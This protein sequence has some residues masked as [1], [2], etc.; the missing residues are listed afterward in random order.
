LPRRKHLPYLQNQI[1]NTQLTVH[2]ILAKAKLKPFNHFLALCELGVRWPHH[3]DMKNA[4][5]AIKLP[6]RHRMRH[7]MIDPRCQQLKKETEGMSEDEANFHFCTMSKTAKEVFD[8]ELS[9][10][11]GA[12]LLR[13]GAATLQIVDGG[14]HRHMCKQYL[15]Y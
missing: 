15:H 6:E 10:V 13:P 11:S 14:N 12:G 8:S 9:H 7:N 4:H 3:K 1:P 2:Q 5:G